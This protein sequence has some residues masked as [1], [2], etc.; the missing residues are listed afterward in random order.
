MHSVFEGNQD[1]ATLL[2]EKGCDFQLHDKNSK[3]PF[4]EA[5]MKKQN[6]VNKF[7]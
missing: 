2:L 4:E 1:M 5:I 3:S 6:K 7:F